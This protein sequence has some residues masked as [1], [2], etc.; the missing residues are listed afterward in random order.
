MKPLIAGA[1]A[2]AIVAFAPGARARIP[3]TYCKTA[4]RHEQIAN[5]CMFVAATIASNTEH[6]G[7][8]TVERAA[9]ACITAA[10]NIL[11]DN[12]TN[13]VYSRELLAIDVK[14]ATTQTAEERA[15]YF[16]AA[17]DQGRVIGATFREQE[18]SRCEAFF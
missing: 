4:K 14:Q 15:K 9:N 3:H 5:R 12:E 6:K 11:T 17:Y 7:S 13:D 8:D 1:I 18:H 10:E 2:A 16:L